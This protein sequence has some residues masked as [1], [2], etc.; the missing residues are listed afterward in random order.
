MA[1]IL[2]WRYHDDLQTYAQDVR[3]CIVLPATL[4][5]AKYTRKFWKNG[6]WVYVY[7]A[8]TIGSRKRTLEETK[9]AA[10][11]G[12][13]RAKLYTKERWGSGFKNLSNKELLEEYLQTNNDLDRFDA[14]PNTTK[15]KLMMTFAAV[16][17]GAV[18]REMD[19]RGLGA[20][21]ANNLLAA[22]DRE[23]LN[24]AKYTRRWKGKDGKWNYEYGKPSKGDRGKAEL[25]MT[26]YSRYKGEWKPRDTYEAFVKDNFAIVKTETARLRHTSDMIADKKLREKH[27][28]SGMRELCN[29][30][31]TI[32][33]S[34]NVE[35][36]EKAKYT[37]RW[38]GKD[39]KWNYEYGKPKI[40]KPTALLE[41]V[42]KY[43]VSETK[44]SGS[45]SQVG[46]IGAGYARSE[47]RGLKGAETRSFRQLQALHK[48]LHPEDKHGQ[49]LINLIMRVK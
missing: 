17:G 13:I 28:K 4:I 37:R 18:F 22:A 39:G 1:A 44:L 5:K 31:T 23:R 33:D 3:S 47:S 41:A 29:Q 15:R 2:I 25:N 11:Y 27:F 19:S 32:W 46:V 20:T 43:I 12:A 35:G 26:F 38:K 45:V 21:D 48:E 8:M 16:R 7:S 49:G 24:K 34:L 6:R 10:K 42:K 30:L 14:M 40:S 36:L 9:Q